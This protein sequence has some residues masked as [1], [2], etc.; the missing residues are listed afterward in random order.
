MKKGI[1][2]RRVIQFWLILIV[3]PLSACRAS[4]ATSLTSVCVQVVQSYAGLSHTEPIA[5]EIQDILS[6]V[7]VEVIIGKGTECEAELLLTMSFTPVAERIFG[8]DLCYIDAESTGEATLSANGQNTL[9]LSLDHSKSNWGGSGIW[10]IDACPRP[11]QAPFEKAWSEGVANILRKWWGNQALVS[12]VISDN[13]A[14]RRAATNQL[15]SIGSKVIPE[16]VEM[17]DA[18]NPQ[19]REAAADALGAF[20]SDATD[21]VPALIEATN[22]PESSVQSAALIALGNI[23][24]SQVVPTL[25]TALHHSDWHIRY[26]AAGALKNMGPTAAP[27][28][29]DLIDALDDEESSVREA[30]FDALGGIGTEARQAIPALIES[31]ED[32]DWYDCHLAANALKSITGQDFGEDATAWRTWWESQP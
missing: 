12:A 19:M 10:V 28:V 25:I 16:L 26:V 15:K 24:D 30:A 2:A 3:M 13:E 31:L 17:L 8:G 1:F 29:P 7:G 14:M 23:G 18:T 4:W 22:D 9:T 32:E 11:D 21:A 5:E 6:R 20:D 27:A